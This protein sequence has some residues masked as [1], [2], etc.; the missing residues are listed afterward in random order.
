VKEIAYIEIIKRK[1]MMKNI[2]VCMFTGEENKFKSIQICRM[3][4][5]WF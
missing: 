2:L 3:R 4:K 5:S 1:L